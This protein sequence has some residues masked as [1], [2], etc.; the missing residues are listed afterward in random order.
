MSRGTLSSYSLSWAPLPDDR[1]TGRNRRTSDSS[2]H[3]GGTYYIRIASRSIASSSTDGVRSIPRATGGASGPAVIAEAALE[4]E[5]PNASDSDDSAD[6]GHAVDQ[7]SSIADIR[8]AYQ[9]EQ[10]KQAR[11]AA[12]SSDDDEAP[13]RPMG[14][15]P[16]PYVTREPPISGAATPFAELPF[17]G[18]YPK[19]NDRPLAG[20]YP[21]N[22][23]VRLP[24]LNPN[25]IDRPV[26]GLYPA[27]PPARAQVRAVASQVQSRDDRVPAKRLGA[28]P[29]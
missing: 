8:A 23:T 14:P 16:T 19:P 9:R 25:R 21:T 26:T 13:P 1:V 11:R 18:L 28:L 10:A 20:L 6:G 15:A 7:H 4:V 24:R 5:D 27:A 12:A 3:T 2:L 17:S 29:Q 22:Q